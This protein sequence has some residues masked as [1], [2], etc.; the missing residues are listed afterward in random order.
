MEILRGVWKHPLRTRAVVGYGVKIFH[1]SP[2]NYV[3]PGH[4]GVMLKLGRRAR[5]HFVT[6]IEICVDVIRGMCGHINLI[7][8]SVT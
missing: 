7:M 3:L 5:E 4:L 1:P 2:P 6:L 8:G